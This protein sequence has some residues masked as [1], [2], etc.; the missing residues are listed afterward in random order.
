[1]TS[2]IKKAHAWATHMAA[3]ALPAL[4]AFACM[5]PFVVHAQGTVAVLPGD[6]TDI[7]AMANLILGA[8]M[9]KQWGLLASLL[10]LLTVAGLRK[11]V[12]E[13]SKLGGWLRTK[14]GGIIANFAVTLSGTFATMFLAG[15]PFSFDMVLKAL[16]VALSAA[17]GWAI[18][19]NVSEAMDELKAQ[20]T[21]LAA[22]AAPDD[23]LNK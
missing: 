3:K 4:V 20:K 1:M 11:W 18:F 13:T 14:L 22:A 15:A 21:G 9:N 16:S 17:G 7:G 23:T 2:F 19:K 12:P 10:V 5:I 6:P 8:V